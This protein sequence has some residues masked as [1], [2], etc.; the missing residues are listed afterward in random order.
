LTNALETDEI[1]RARWLRRNFD[2]A[3]QL[4]DSD[5]LGEGRLARVL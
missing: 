2:Q 3:T 4:L 1:N 5:W